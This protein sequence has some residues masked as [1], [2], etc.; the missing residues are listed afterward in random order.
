ML[1]ACVVKY[2][3]YKIYSHINLFSIKS[4]KI[5]YS[6]IAVRAVGARGPLNFGHSRGK[7]VA[8]PSHFAAVS[9][10]DSKKVSIY[11]ILSLF[12]R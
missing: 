2:R 1:L 10:P 11:L 9:F 7:V 8:H 4:L 3:Q 12:L 5:C 6:L